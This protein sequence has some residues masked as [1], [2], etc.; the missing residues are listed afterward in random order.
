M[1]LSDCAA[2]LSPRSTADG[3]FSL[4]SSA[5]AE[6]FHSASGALSE[7]RHTVVGPAELE[8]FP[9]G[10]T[11]VV[12]DVCV[13]TG[14][15]TAA[16]LEAAASRQLQLHWRGLELD[17]RPLQLALAD[18]GFGAQWSAEALAPLHQLAA[19]GHWSSSLGSGEILW[20][21]ARGR[22]AELSSALQGQ[23]DL[24]LH[25]AFSPRRCPQLWSL[26][27]L[28]GLAQLLAPQGRLLSYCSAA[29]V[30]ASLKLA[31]LQL[32]S[33]QRPQQP[34]GS[35]ER[36]CGGTAASPSALPASTWLRPLTPMELEHLGTNA[37]EP[38]RDPSGC[39]SAAQLLAQRSLQQQQRLARGEIESTSAWRR[40]WGLARGST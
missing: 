6:R 20:G 1:T 22:L 30:R 31:G 10:S 19:A 5:F 39:N 8:R 24:V 28:A 13:G 32:A 15:N 16:L 11:V 34:A 37:A 4:F 36:W 38:Y 25:D 35:L 23:V 18:R 2:E 12:V 7:A 17:S 29:A 21:D 14:S 33:L 3:S 40:R 26:E 9:P 27:F